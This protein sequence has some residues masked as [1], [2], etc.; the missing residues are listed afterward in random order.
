MVAVYPGTEPPETRRFVLSDPRIPLGEDVPE[1]LFGYRNPN[2]PNQALGATGDGYLQAASNIA[3][4]IVNGTDIIGELGSGGSFGFGDSKPIA[5]GGKTVVHWQGVESPTAAA[6]SPC[7]IHC[8]L[9]LGRLL[10][11]RSLGVGCGW[12]IDPPSYP[13]DASPH[14]Q[15]PL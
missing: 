12:Q 4:S 6:A 1:A 13:G 15:K 8:A 7:M 14:R 3:F 2:A 5:R 9:F 10:L 11:P